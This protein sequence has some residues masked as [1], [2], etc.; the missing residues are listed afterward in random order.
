MKQSLE[1]V[2]SRASTASS[3]LKSRHQTLSTKSPGLVQSREAVY[4]Q[5]AVQ[6]RESVLS[7][8]VSQSGAAITSAFSWSCHQTLS[9]RFPGVA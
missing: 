7:Q 6:S 5:E 4:Y 1:A 8:E 2:Q 3:S 9:T